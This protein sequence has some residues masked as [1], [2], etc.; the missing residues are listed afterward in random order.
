MT[1]LLQAV[2]KE[3]W[4]ATCCSAK[5]VGMLGGV[6]EAGPGLTS[7]LAVTSGKHMSRGWVEFVEQSNVSMGMVVSGMI[8]VGPAFT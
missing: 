5:Q 2:P 7:V 6:G 4:S 1:Q 3:M 8:T